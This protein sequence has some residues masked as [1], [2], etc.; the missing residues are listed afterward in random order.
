MATLPRM[1]PKTFY[2][3]AVEVALI[4]PRPHPGGVGPSLPPPPQWGGANP[5]SPST[6]RAD[7]QEDPWCAGV[8]GTAD[9][10]GSESVPGLTGAN[11]IGCGQR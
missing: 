10:A 6:Y 3:L 9:G 5:L 2:D 7:P 1:K 4:R 11:P 8:S